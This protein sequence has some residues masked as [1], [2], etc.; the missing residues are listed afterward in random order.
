MGTGK[1]TAAEIIVN[2]VRNS[3]ML[4]GDWCWQQGC[5]WHFDDESKRMAMDNICHLL[6]S[7]MRNSHIENVIFCWVLHLREI[8]DEI[9]AALRA[10]GAEFELFDISL[11]TDEIHI[12]QRLRERALSA[13]R[14]RNLPCDETQLD[15][16]TARTMERMRHYA[17]LDTIKLDTSNISPDEVAREIITIAGLRY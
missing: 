17:E 5:D 15:A 2:T 13:A 16:V 8:H 3:V 6:K 14:A 10:D 1:T 11:M 7:F 9:T 4:D 12:K